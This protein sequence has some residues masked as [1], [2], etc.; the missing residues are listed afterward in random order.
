MR[1]LHLGD[2][3]IDADFSSANSYIASNAYITKLEMLERI[4]EFVSANSV[5]MVVIA[6]DL[7]DNI[8]LSKNIIYRVNKWIMDLLKLGVH[9]VYVNGNHDYWVERD[10]FS[11]IQSDRFVCICEEEYVQKVLKIGD[12]EV[13]VH[14]FGYSVKNPL[15][16][17]IDFF[18]PKRDDRIH[19]GVMHGVV[20]NNYSADKAPYYPA[21][22]VEINRLNYDYF[23]LGHVHRPIDINERCKYSGGFYPRYYGDYSSYGGIVAEIGNTG[24]RSR[25]VEFT[26]KKI[27]DVEIEIPYIENI[28][29]YN[30]LLQYMYSKDIMRYLTAEN[31]LNIRLTGSIFFNWK[32]EYGER[33]L[34]N[35]F[36]NNSPKHNIVNHLKY[37]KSDF[38]ISE[39]TEFNEL[40]D[41][42]YNNLLAHLRNGESLKD[43]S[44]KNVP[45][46]IAL[47]E[48]LQIFETRQEDIKNMIFEY[49]GEHNVD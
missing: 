15:K 27:V 25:R 17:V 37:V 33:L 14:G 39:N 4:T 16:K 36:L 18:M 23:A 2:I 26:E 43:A 45:N 34:R 40:M 38:N 49:M 47:S 12:K 30:K 21:D 22:E 13:V 42:A 46:L 20:E 10:T 8:T 11:I 3:H 31:M 41:R 24:F 44:R 19:I 48:Q 35:L 1:L 32:F 7:Y 5:D 29:S 6:G 9:V 28:N